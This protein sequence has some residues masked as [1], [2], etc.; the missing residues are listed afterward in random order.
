MRLMHRHLIRFAA[1]LSSL[2]PIAGTVRSATATEP[3]GFC[4]SLNF[5]GIVVGVSEDSHVERLLGAN[6]FSDR[7]DGRDRW[8]VDPAKS[9]T[10]RVSSCTDRVV[11]ELSVQKG[12][13]ADATAAGIDP[14]VSSFFDPQEGFGKWRSL[15][16]GSQKDHVLANLGPPNE[17]K[18]DGSWVYQRSCTCE[19]PEYLTIYFKNE[20]ISR[21]VLSAPPG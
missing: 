16:L 17:K 9:A 10:I 19:L 15:H 12:L 18:A 6:R 21:I 2:I 11:C 14:K 8:Y 5:A 20:G 13:D 1:A 3:E 7:G 4:W